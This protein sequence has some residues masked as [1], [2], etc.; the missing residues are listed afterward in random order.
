MMRAMGTPLRHDL[1]FL[2]SIVD[3]ASRLHPGRTPEDLV[4]LGVLRDYLA[5]LAID[6]MDDEQ[7][8]R[9]L[10]YD[11]AK[12]QEELLTETEKNRALD[13]DPTSPAFYEGFLHGLEQA[14]S[15]R[16]GVDLLLDEELS[17]REFLESWE[18]TRKRLGL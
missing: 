4:T 13:I 17:Q 10:V 18:R 2:R 1:M 6:A 7:L 14:I 5:W 11:T 16:C 15:F 8:A 12:I 9:R 3:E